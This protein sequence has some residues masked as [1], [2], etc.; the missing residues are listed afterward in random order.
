MQYGH[1][2]LGKGMQQ[3]LAETEA[4]HGAGLF[5]PPN[6]FE[7]GVQLCSCAPFDLHPPPMDE[8]S[9]RLWLKALNLKKPPNRPY[10]CSYHLVDKRPTEEHPFPEK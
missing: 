7:I 3:L 6:L 9:L 10:E 1:L 2:M 8:E 5:C 4:V